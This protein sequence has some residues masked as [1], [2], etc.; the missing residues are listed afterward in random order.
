M[1]QANRKMPGRCIGTLLSALPERFTLA[2][3]RLPLRWA[4]HCEKPLSNRI[5]WPVLLPERLQISALCV[6][7]FAF[8][9]FVQ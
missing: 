9:G 6:I 1:W 4:S 5:N 8:G 2:M 3:Q 7:H